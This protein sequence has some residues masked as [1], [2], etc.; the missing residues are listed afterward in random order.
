MAQQVSEKMEFAKEEEKILQFWEDVDAFKTCLEQSKNKKKF[1]FYDGP[2]FATGKPHYGHILAGTI[3]DVVTRYAHQT[4][5]H[6][7]RRFG[8]DCHGVPVE[9]IIDK[10]LEIKSPQQVADMGIAKYNAECRSIVM[11]YSGEWETTVNRLGR[12][13]DFRND[14]KTLYPWFMESVWWT[15]KQIFDGGNV[16]QGTRVMPFSTGLH[17]PLSNFE[18]GQNYKE[19]QDPAVVVNFPME[20]D[21][22]VKLVAWTTTPWTLPSNLAL[23]VNPEEVYVKVK[24]NKTGE[25]YILME[26]RLVELFKKPTGY[27]ILGEKFLGKTLKNKKYKPLFNYFSNMKSDKE[28]EGAFRVLLDNYVTSE[29]GT[30]VVHQAPFFGADDHRV[31]GEWKVYKKSEV[32]CPVDAKGCFTEEVPDFVGQYVKDAD[33]L[34][35]KKLK[36]EGRMVKDSQVKHNYP[37]CWRSNTPLIYKAVPTWFIQVEKHREKLLKNNSETYWVPN[38]VKDKRF[39]NW[40]KN[41]Q[42]WGFSRN[43]YWGTPI[44]IWASEDM[45]EMVC[46]GSIEE[47]QR[48]SGKKVTDIHREFVDDITIP[49]K[50]GKGV[51]RRIS[52]VFDCWFESGSMPYAQ[53]HYPFENQK[54]FEC[55]FPADFIAEGIDQ[56][57][58]WFYTLLVISTLLFDKPPFKNLI[59]NG[60][61]LAHDGQKMSKSKQNYPDPMLVINEYG[62]DA[63]RLYLVNSPVVRGDDLRFKKEGVKD[64]VKNVF[65]PWYNAYRFLIQNVLRF[66]KETGKS[67]EFSDEEQLDVENV[68]DKWILSYT[69]SLVQFV[70]QEMKA[71]KLY[72]VTPKLVKFIETLT[73]WYVR[74]N[75]NRLKSNSKDG[76]DALQVLFTV[77]FT[78]C[79]LMA[80]FTPF[81]TEHMYQN[82]KNMMPSYKEDKNKQSIH[83]LMQ[84]ESN[85]NLLDEEVEKSMEGM[86][87][88]VELARYIRDNKNLPQKYP[89]PELVIIHKDQDYLRR[90]ESLKEYVQE[91]V[92]VKKVTFTSDKS[93]YGAKVRAEPDHLLLGSRLKK[94]FRKVMKKI[95][96][97]TSAECEEV[98]EKGKCVVEGH[99]VAENEMRFIYYLDSEKDDNNLYEAKSDSKVLVLLDLKLTNEM[100]EEGLSREV[101]NRVQKLRKKASLVATDEAT[102]YYEFVDQ[103]GF[104]NELMKKVVQNNEEKI[105]QQTK[106]GVKKM[107]AYKLADV[108]THEVSD[109]KFEHNKADVKSLLKLTL[110]MGKL[111]QVENS[112]PAC[113]F[114]QVSKTESCAVFLENPKNKKIV[115]SMDELSKLSCKLLDLNFDENKLDCGD[116]DVSKLSGKMVNLTT[117]S[118]TSNCTDFNYVNV[119]SVSHRSV[120]CLQLVP[121]MNLKKEV[122]LLFSDD[123]KSCNVYYDMALTEEVDG[124]KLKSKSSVYCTF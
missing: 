2:P 85:T 87:S 95:Q 73:N 105:S 59:V 58:G 99:E 46:V 38:H 39:G 90:V 113:P 28:D 106:T 33:K 66:E 52:E 15:F 35:N 44:P 27:K 65:L 17:T 77:V 79:K 108:V 31:C 89:V 109:I 114:V 40:L 104:N 55:N 23:C 37:F 30:G 88:V 115:N 9:Y 103:T 41:A 92:N 11:K 62:S 68:M 25:V 69:Q 83:Y 29:S 32:V 81:L 116:G 93:K 94:N 13:I 48:L 118:V 100:I 3:K 49:S 120:G 36:Q 97:L 26:A 34:I 53:Q 71:Y 80:P 102:V 122:A 10:K 54:Q 21:P 19:V 22:N 101:V 43:R 67:L 20:E 24:C 51:L 16:Y 78:M 8:W 18:A 84:P 50:K 91:E 110:A 5:H 6:V 121:G 74:M 61:V 60:L 124:S 75:R 112:G 123:E 117:E 7:E 56:T 64:I 42:D 47:L 111:P 14:Y 12:W 86:Q 45:E 1:N 4:G 70:Q 96:E 82:L 72:T 98:L 57:R 76:K 107:P 119:V 63:L